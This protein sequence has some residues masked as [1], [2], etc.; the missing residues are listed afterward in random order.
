MQFMRRLEVVLV[1]TLAGCAVDATLDPGKRCDADHHC[2]YDHVCVGGLCLLPSGSSGGGAGGSSGGGAGVGGG[3]EA[4]GSGGSTGGGS[5]GSTGGGSGGSTGGGSG[6]STGGGSGGSTGGGSGG[7]T[8]GGSGGSTGGGSGGGSGDGGVP[9][10][11]STCPSGSCSTFNNSCH[12]LL[13]ADQCIQSGP[14]S[15]CISC[16]NR[17]DGCSLAQGCMC[18]PTALCSVTQICSAGNCYDAGMG[19]CGTC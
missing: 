6:G 8:G 1:A 13:R 12:M 16:G 11:P 5:G 7:S 4:G 3:G 10:S 2:L 19:S 9:C 15:R 17:A 18:G 14:G